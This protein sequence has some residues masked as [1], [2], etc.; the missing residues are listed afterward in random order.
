VRTN[1]GKK[2]PKHEKK[3]NVAYRQNWNGAKR[4]E[5]KMNQEDMNWNDTQKQDKPPVPL[6]SPVR[7]TIKVTLWWCWTEVEPNETN[8]QNVTGDYL[9]KWDRNRK[10]NWGWELNVDFC[11]VTL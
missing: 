2:K 8:G 1:W 7:C 3:E 6:L 4:K 5:K 10:T 9:M 11:N